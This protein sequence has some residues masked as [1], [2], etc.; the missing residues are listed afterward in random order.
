[1][2][3]KLLLLALLFQSIVLADTF[4][5]ESDAKVITIKNPLNNI[6]MLVEKDMSKEIY[7]RKPIDLTHKIPP[8]ISTPQL[9]PKMKKPKLPHVLKLIRDDFETPKAFQLSVQKTA[10]QREGELKR[11]QEQYRIDV[12]KR[13]NTIEELALEYNRKIEARNHELKKLQKL[14]DDDLKKLKSYYQEKEREAK[15][16]LSHYAANAV[17]RI[18]GKPRL[19][20]KSYNADTEMMRLLVTSYDG[21]NFQKDVTMK[22]PLEKAKGLKES[23]VTNTPKVIFDINMA[24][25][26][27]ISFSI[28]EISIAYKGKRYIANDTTSFTTT[29]PVYVTIENAIQDFNAKSSELSLQKADQTLMLQNPNLS[30]TFTLGAVAFAA[31]G[32]IVGANELVNIIRTLPTPKVDRTKWLFMI[33]VENY[34]ETDKVEYAQRSAVAMRDI[35][36]KRLGINAKHTYALFD[37]KATSGAIK[38]KLQAMLVR[39]K[40]GDSI[41]FY[42]SGHGVPSKEGDAFILPSDKVVD[43]IE[44]DPFFKLENIYAML[45]DSKAAHSFVFVDACFSGKTDN[46]L[47]FKGVAPGLIKTKKIPYDKR[48]MTIMTAGQDNE[49]SNMY[50]E[51]RYRLFSYYLTKALIDNINDIWLL[52]KKVNVNVLQK[53]KELGSRYEQ[54]PQIYGN[55]KVKL[56]K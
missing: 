22:I 15:K 9:P 35:L 43:F 51:K 40:S 6:L 45:S 25:N 56:D 29:A 11:L 10:K 27:S 36:K 55:Q 48:K 14:Q 49:F 33:A 20:Y 37:T 3:K 2:F 42:Y 46:R 50:K 1:M 13:N 34:Q 24:D 23:L 38:D 32:S 16:E 52:Y 39:V 8:N 30:D 44:K 19:L 26:K 21:R 31:N 53:S 4:E 18:Y 54:N 47:L 28:K 41:Y 12:Q 5:W 17:S 7:G